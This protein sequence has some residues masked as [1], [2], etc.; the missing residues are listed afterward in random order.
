MLGWDETSEL[1]LSLVKW[2]LKLGNE[3]KHESEN[4][5][6][7]HTPKT[8]SYCISHQPEAN[9]WSGPA[10]AE[11]VPWVAWLQTIIG[12]PQMTHLLNKWSVKIQQNSHK[13]SLWVCLSKQQ[14]ASSVPRWH[15]LQGS[16]LKPPTHVKTGFP[17]TEATP[18]K[19]G[20]WTVCWK[21]LQP[22]GYH[23][24][25]PWDP[26]HILSEPKAPALHCSFPQMVKNLCGLFPQKAT[27]DQCAFG[28]LVVVQSG[29]M[30]SEAALP[31]TKL[32]TSL[33]QSSN[34]WSH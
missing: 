30:W 34:Q 10:V 32:V 25:T 4:W 16:W 5:A 6:I 31:G 22:L 24:V 14:P 29:T 21:L 20:T 28:G 19:H 23:F 13:A 11:M 26:C 15:P 8:P 7:T 9:G 33:A 3:R 1:D 12:R 18:R 2:F 27:C 17:S